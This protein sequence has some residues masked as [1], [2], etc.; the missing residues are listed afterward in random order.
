[1]KNLMKQ[2]W[3]IQ[4]GGGLNWNGNRSIVEHCCSQFFSLSRKTGGEYYIIF[5]PNHLYH[6]HHL[7]HFWFEN[8]RENDILRVSETKIAFTMDFDGV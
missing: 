5:F 8:G 3:K 1:M 2:K 7:Y 6:L 4:R